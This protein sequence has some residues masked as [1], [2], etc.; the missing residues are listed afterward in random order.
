MDLWRLKIFCKVVEKGSFSKAAEDVLL[1]QPTVSSH[2]KDLEEYFG[3]RL[4]DRIGRR[5]VLTG[6][7]E[8]L[9]SRASKL[10]AMHDQMVAEMADYQGRVGGR[11]V[12]GGST[13]PSGYILPGLI[14]AYRK[15]Y[16][17][18]TV[19]LVVGDTAK[20]VSNILD[21]EVELGVVGG[22]VNESGIVQE[23]I[24]ID[25]MK[26]VV[27]SSHPWA[28]RRS[29]R[30]SELVT[31]PFI[32]RERG[33]GTLE[34][35]EAAIAVK[36]LKISDFNIVAQIGSTEAV[37]QGIKNGIGVSVLSSV[38]VEEYVR[39]GVLAMVSV[40]DIDLTRMFYL[41]FLKRRSPSPAG[42]AF[43]DMVM[44]I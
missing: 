18:V 21:G 32:V 41:T 34:A 22:R 44:G 20:I 25:E 26:L 33:S 6:A 9:Y 28:G 43:L 27:H 16:P 29:V 36:G 1:S 3:C 5:L 19:L 2:M 10:L 24:L 11:L 42:R 12:V 15:S 4:I 37:I 8:L 14:G 35:F 39:E 31:Q 40:S 23:G 38:A 30:A 17:D 13:I 7:G